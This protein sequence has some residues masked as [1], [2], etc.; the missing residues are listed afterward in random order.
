LQCVVGVVGVVEQAAAQEPYQQLGVLDV[1]VE[2]V[3]VVG[4]AQLSVE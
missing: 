4:D 3:E 1:L 2:T